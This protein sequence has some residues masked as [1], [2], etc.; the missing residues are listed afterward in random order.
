MS[1]SADDRHDRRKCIGQIVDRIQNDRDGVGH[2]PDERFESDEQHVRQDT[3]DAGF[4][5]RF[6]SVCRKDVNII[7]LFFHT[8]L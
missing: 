6:L 5:D 2:Q 1:D 4:N 3:D 8:V 7:V